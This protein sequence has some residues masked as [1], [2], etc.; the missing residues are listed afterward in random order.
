M[1]ET[2]P[3]TW[4]RA[5]NW[6][7]GHVL[8]MEAAHELGLMHS[9]APDDTCVVVI[10]HD[11]DLANDID[12]EPEVELIPGR[13]LPE[14]NGNFLGGKSPRTLHLRMLRDNTT[15]VV[16]L[17]NTAKRT[18]LKTALAQ[19]QPDGA[20]SLPP[21]EWVTL[22][23]WLASRYRRAAFANNLVAR[24]KATGAETALANALKKHGSLVAA[25]YFRVEGGPQI[26]R[27]PGDP[28]EITIVLMFDP[29]ND[30][31][32]S[33]QAANTLAEQLARTLR[34]KFDGQ[35]DMRLRDCIPISEDDVTVR[36]VKSLSQWRLEYMTHRAAQEQP[37]PP[38]A[39]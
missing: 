37:G 35:A 17:L 30:A 6:R 18:A 27:A 8:P 5:T 4:T 36:M 15:V 23:G 3:A 26:E 7:Q 24:M 11:C 2:T 10:S 28:Y 12:I 9:E 21:R 16:E 1:Q 22:Q 20:Y 31:E 34:A 39:P 32:A 14:A 38:D 25:V 29:G 13:I 19:W 33:S